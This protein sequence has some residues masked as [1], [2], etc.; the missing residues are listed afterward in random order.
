MGKRARS[1]FGIFSFRVRPQAGYQRMQNWAFFP[2]S[3]KV[4]KVISGL[5]FVSSFFGSKTI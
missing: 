5:S 4:G 2:L 3:N 1:W